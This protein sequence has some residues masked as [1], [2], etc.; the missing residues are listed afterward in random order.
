M[1][2][3][4]VGHILSEVRCL[5]MGLLVFFLLV[6]CAR[7]EQP[8][9]IDNDIAKNIQTIERRLPNYKYLLELGARAAANDLVQ[10]GD[11][12][13]DPVLI[14]MRRKDHESLRMMIGLD[15][16]FRVNSD[17]SLAA[18]SKLFSEYYGAPANNL[19][20]VDSFAYDIAREA[21]IRDSGVSHQIVE[22][23]QEDDAL[24]LAWK[25]AFR[26]L[27]GSGQTM[28]EK[29]SLRIE[30]DGY[31]VGMFPFL[32]KIIKR[33]ASDEKLLEEFRSW[34][35]SVLASDVLDRREF[36]LMVVAIETAD[37]A[38]LYSDETLSKLI[39]RF[40]EDGRMWHSD[41]L[42]RNKSYFIGSGNGDAK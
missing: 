28:P 19:S 33:I 23:I 15:I 2:K 3:I 24:Y 39:T 36:A 11:L 26:I 10:H 37:Y 27:S 5:L 41:L 20:S 7:S 13:V 6:L 25:D 9:D 14:F 8:A 22:L 35:M 30:P 21:I 38:Y 12:C 29:L 40:E 17:K 1:K 16:L 18:I 34:Y 4:D 32:P 42:K 31:V